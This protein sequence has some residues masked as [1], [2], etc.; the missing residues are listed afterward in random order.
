MRLQ[1]SNEIIVY[2]VVFVAQLHCALNVQLNVQLRDFESFNPEI[3]L[4][5][6]FNPE[7]TLIML[8]PRI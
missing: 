4:I 5:M 8:K 1:C 2:Y 3:I 7:I 6:L